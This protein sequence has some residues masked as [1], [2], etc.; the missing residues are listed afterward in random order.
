MSWF[1]PKIRGRGRRKRRP[2]KYKRVRRNPGI[3]VGFCRR[4]LVAMCKFAAFTAVCALVALAGYQAHYFLLKS[5]HYR[6]RTVQISG[7]DS[8]RRGLLSRSISP[9]PQHETKRQARGQGRDLCARNEA[10]GRYTPEA[11]TISRQ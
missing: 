8:R 10:S 4:L 1:V 7:A 5:P 9:G 6:L 2:R 3:F 11:S